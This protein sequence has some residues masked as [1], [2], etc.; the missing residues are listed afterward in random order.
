MAKRSS[1][2]TVACMP[3]SQILDAM[4]FNILLCLLDELREIR[5][6]YTP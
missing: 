2:L 3:G 6:R 4:S 1:A 5:N